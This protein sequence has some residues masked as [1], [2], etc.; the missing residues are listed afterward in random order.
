MLLHPAVCFQI[1]FFG[2]HDR[3]P[4][5]A[6]AGSIVYS[7]IAVDTAEEVDQ[8]DVVRELAFLFE[9]ELADRSVSAEMIG[10][11]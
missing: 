3:L 6:V 4:V 8:L 11:S 10:L 1:I 5:T 2:P 9:L 7:S